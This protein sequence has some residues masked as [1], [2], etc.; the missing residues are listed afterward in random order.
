MNRADTLA[1]NI[2]TTKPLLLRFAEDFDE[3]MVTK[4]AD[5]LANHV[6]WVLGHCALTMQRVGEMFDGV[7]L[8]ETDFLMGN[9][10]QGDANRFDTES[11]C[12]ESVPVDDPSMYPNLSRS[13]E[14]FSNAC[15]R[16]ADSV[17]NSPD[18][19][20]DEEL[21]WHDGPMPFWKLVARV[22]FHNG[23]HA[24][25]LIDLRRALGMGRIIKPQG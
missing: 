2:L 12:I 7:S 10:T 20:F 16:F 3:S 21:P 25:Q 22:C 11:V 9:G 13:I 1:A 18:E 5:G 23:A 19:K 4:Q 8:P 17:R 24:G 15:D 14:I 6:V